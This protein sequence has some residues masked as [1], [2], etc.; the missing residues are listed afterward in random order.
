M[1]DVERCGAMKPEGVALA[2]VLAATAVLLLLLTRRQTL[3]CPFNRRIGVALD[4]AQHG[5]V[6]ATDGSAAVHHFVDTAKMVADELVDAG[7]LGAEDRH[8]KL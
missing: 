3:S 6:D 1:R 4:V 5:H 2:D 7:V 8:A